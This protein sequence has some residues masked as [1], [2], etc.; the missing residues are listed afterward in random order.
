MPT[1]IV[2]IGTIPHYNESRGAVNVFA[3]VKY[4][5][6][7]LSITGVEGPK[8]NGDAYGSCGQIVMSYRTPENRATITPAPGWDA[9]TVD[10]FFALWDRWHLNDM[11]AGTPRQEA[12]LR[13]NPVTAVYPE[14]HYEKA[15]QALAAAGLNPDTEWER[16]ASLSTNVKTDGGYRYGTAWLHED[17]PADVIEWLFALPDTD[18][19]PAWV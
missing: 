10:R 3:E 14:S 7:R 2:R 5:N 19:T 9:D 16:P 15:C 6:G 13:E 12:Y 4:N 11:T 17:V 1:K 8:S 18:K